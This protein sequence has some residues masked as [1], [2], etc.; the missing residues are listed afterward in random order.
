MERRGFLKRLLGLGV[1][2]AAMTV[3]A[4]AKAAKDDTFTIED[5]FV[6]LPGNKNMYYIKKDS[7]LNQ[8]L[9]KALGDHYLPKDKFG[10]YYGVYNQYIPVK[11]EYTIEDFRQLIMFFED[12][13]ERFDYFCDGQL[14]DVEPGLV[15]LIK[16]RSG[17]FYHI[18]TFQAFKHGMYGP[19][20]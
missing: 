19:K 20:D 11:D 18:D 10:C 9:M 4:L 12:K 2:A 14:R 15:R 5:A 6:Q 1:G 13:R 8:E 17:K 3:P 16:D 7:M